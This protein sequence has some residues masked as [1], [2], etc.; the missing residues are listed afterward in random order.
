[1]CLTVGPSVAAAALES[2]KR[3]S[4]IDKLAV[5]CCERHCVSLYIYFV[6]NGTNFAVSENFKFFQSKK[7]CAYV[8]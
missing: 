7:Q 6:C 2:T 3:F 1:M 8:I 5:S 4:H